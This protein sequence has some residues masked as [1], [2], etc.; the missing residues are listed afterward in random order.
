MTWRSDEKYRG[1]LIPVW[2]WTEDSLGAVEQ[3]DG[4]IVRVSSAF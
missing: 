3:M 2:R 1:S 4:L